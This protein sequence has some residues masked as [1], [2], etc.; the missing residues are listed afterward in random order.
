M[1]ASYIAGKSVMM[2]HGPWVW[3]KAKAAGSD[4]PSTARRVARHAAR[5]RPGTWMQGALPPNIDNQWWMR[6]GV[7]NC[8]TGRRS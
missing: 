1:E 7:E 8:R 2:L 3:D 5:R 6:A 4:S